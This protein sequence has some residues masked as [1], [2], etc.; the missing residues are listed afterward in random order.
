MSKIIAVVNQKGGVGKTTTAI[1]L[2]VFLAQQGQ[3]GL[4]V[5]MD[6]QA[7]A[8]SGLGVEVNKITNGVYKVLTQ[9]IGAR[10]AIMPSVIPGLDILPASMDLAGGVVELVNQEKREHRLARALREVVDDYDYIVIDCPPSLDLLTINSLVAAR[11]VLIPVQ[12]EY[13]ALEGLSQLLNTLDLIRE[14]LNPGLEILGAVITMY[15]QRQRLAREVW[16]EMYRHFPGRVFRTAI[17]RNVKLAEAP[18]YRQSVFDYAHNS[19][20]ARAYEELGREI[21]GQD[22]DL[23]SLLID[24]QYV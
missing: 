5:D 11:Q 15:E 13:F 2:A 6:P 8:T 14:S 4:L 12:A 17:P 20:G 7:N 3:R 21:M 23:E 19:R 1:N 9:Q 16:L 10:E 18:S 22:M 24:N